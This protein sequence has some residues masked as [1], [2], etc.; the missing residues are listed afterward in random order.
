MLG[1]DHAPHSAEEKSR[2]FEKSLPGIS[3]LDIELPLWITIFSRTFGLDQ[4]LPM[5]ARKNRKIAEMFGLQGMG[6]LEL[7]FPA[8]ISLVDMSENPVDCSQWFS[9]AKLSPYDG[10]KVLGSV[11]AT[12]VNGEIAFHSG[13]LGERKGRVF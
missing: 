4:G 5:I 7:G 3:S 9:K 8:D 2:D 6:S 1:S 11:F 13:K 10:M 12:L